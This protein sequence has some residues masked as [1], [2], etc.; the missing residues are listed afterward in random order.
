MQRDSLHAEEEGEPGFDKHAF[1]PTLGG[2]AGHGTLFNQAIDAGHYYLQSEWD[3]AGEACLMK[4]LAL[5]DAAIGVGAAIG[6]L[7]GQLHRQRVRPLRR[8]RTQLDFGDGANCD[9]PVSKPHL[10]DRRRIHGDDDAERRAH[11]LDR[12]GGRG[13]VTVAVAALPRSSHRR[14]PPPVI[15]TSLTTTAA[16]KP[17]ERQRRDSTFQRLQSRQLHSHDRRDNVQGDVRDP[18]TFSW[19]ATFKNGKFGAFASTRRCKKGL[20]QAAAAVPAAAKIVFAK[21]SQAVAAAG[22]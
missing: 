2:S 11:G 4:P 6:R 3:N 19:L 14:H 17:S 16:A 21:G 18:G 22:A 5:G 7:A 20:A 12:F 1:T 8:L 10:R 15:T 13:R 9:R